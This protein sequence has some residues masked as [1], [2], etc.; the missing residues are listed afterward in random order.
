MESSIMVQMSTC[1][2]GRMIL[3][4][5]GRHGIPFW[6]LQVLRYPDLIQ[7]GKSF[8]EHM[9]VIQSQMLL[10]KVNVPV[11]WLLVTMDAGFYNSTLSLNRRQKKN[12]LW[13][14]EL[15]LLIKRVEKPL[16]NY[17]TSVWLL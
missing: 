6:V 3:R 7:T 10:Q 14:W 9:E 12:L 8:L 1:L 17:R 16:E 2:P 15:A 11:P 4:K 5:E 13:L